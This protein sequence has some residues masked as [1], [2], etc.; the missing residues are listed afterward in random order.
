MGKPEGGAEAG[1]DDGEGEAAVGSQEEGAER[2]DDLIGRIKAAWPILSLAESMTKL[3]S[4]D[5]RW[6]HGLCPLPGHKDHKPSFWLD[7]ERGVFGC[8]ACAVRGDVVNLY[9]LRHGLTVREAIREMA[10]KLPG[11]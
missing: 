2:R 3:T 9:A 8:Y 6:F 5:G 11:R 4:G 1:N 7:A 10:A